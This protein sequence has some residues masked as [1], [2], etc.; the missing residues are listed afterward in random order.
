[1][2]EIAYIVLILSTALVMG[3]EFSLA[4]FIHPSL[5][6]TDHKAF[7]PAIQVFAKLFGKV[8]PFW[9]TGTLAFHLALA[10]ATWSPHHITS[11]F[12]LSAAAIWIFVVVFSLIF[13]VP[14]NNRVGQWNP[15]ALPS[16]W[17]AERKLWDRY[18]T[19]RVFLIGVAFVLL[20]VAFGHL[21]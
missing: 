19:T 12:T 3:N 13:P 9:M 11:L 4:F 5:T 6:R 14:I 8:M 15:S 21:A 18:N 10:L 16:N 20:L 2:I 7:I 17:E 1:M